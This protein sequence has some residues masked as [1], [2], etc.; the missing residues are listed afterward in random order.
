MFRAFGDRNEFLDALRPDGGSRT[1]DADPD[2]SLGVE[3]QGRASLGAHF[4]LT[5]GTEQQVHRYHGLYTAPDDGTRLLTEVNY[6]VGNT[7]LEGNWQPSAQ[8]NV[9]AG[10][11]RA[12]WRPSLIR[13]ILDG[14]VQNLERSS[15]SRLT[16]RLSVIWK[17]NG[18]DVLKFI[19]GQ[20][21]RF[22]TIFERYYTDTQTQ[23]PNTG[24]KPEIITSQQVSWSRKWN[25][26]W[27][28]HVAVSFFR[29]EEA[30][31]PGTSAQDGMEQYQNAQ[32]PS[33]GRVVEWETAWHRGGLE[34]SGG[35]GWY[36]WTRQG[37][38]LPNASRWNGV[39]K[40]IQHAG[41]WSLAGEARYVAGRENPDTPTGIPTRVPANWT[42]RTSLR[43]ETSWGWGQ[44]SIEDLTNSRRRDLVAPEYQPVTWMAADGR[45][46]RATLGVRF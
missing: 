37:L 14:S 33:Q 9:V 2:R 11:Q 17:A 32:S 46:V 25:P 30:I 12:D 27:S 20:G 43:R 45:S 5:F 40:A 29:G 13:N 35:A 7:Y 10:L 4:T 15:I 8:W 23:V 1:F 34:L 6:A 39:F 16:P 36:D 19:Y 44:V 28:T 38:T 21:F 18:G 3:A 42:L 31:Q 24:L 26:Q 41:N 22:P